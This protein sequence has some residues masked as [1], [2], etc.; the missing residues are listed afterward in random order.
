MESLIIIPTYNEKQNIEFLVN[1]LL[2]LGKNLYVLI[3]DDNSPDGTS[4]I[5]NQLKKKYQEV[6]VLHRKGKLGLG[7]AYVEGFKYALENGA[8]YIFE[9]DADLSYS[10]KFIPD[11]LEAIKTYDLVVGSRY[12][13]GVRVLNWPF[14]RI[15]LSKIGTQYVRMI[16]GLPVTDVTSG[17]R[18]FRREVLETIDLDKIK[19]KGYSFQI[20]MIFKVFH[21][22]F[23]IGE[24]PIVFEER[25]NG[26]SKINKEIVFEAM[27]LIW[28]LQIEYNVEVVFHSV[29][30]ILRKI[31]KNN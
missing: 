8:Q 19:S 15:I 14:R 30:K 18:C 4:E 26:Q 31:I 25:K 12:I 13:G 7:T 23:R 24:I 28:K 10:P 5:A 21:K 3:I 27:W 6:H 17:F 22:G 20:E 11:F 2:S 29:R 9:M 16:T 1:S